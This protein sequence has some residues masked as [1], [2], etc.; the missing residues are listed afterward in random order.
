MVSLGRWLQLTGLLHLDDVAVVLKDPQQLFLWGYPSTI[1]RIWLR[2]IR[3]SIHLVC[4]LSWILSLL[5]PSAQNCLKWQLA[6]AAICHDLDLFLRHG[7]S[8]SVHGLGWVCNLRDVEASA[9][10]Y[11]SWVEDSCAKEGLVPLLN[12]LGWL[13]RFVSLP[14]FDHHNLLLKLLL[15]D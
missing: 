12:S 13:C 7:L 14:N 5:L 6:D 2:H 10:Q 15:H 1:E 11:L 4:L 3:F 9:Y 8:S